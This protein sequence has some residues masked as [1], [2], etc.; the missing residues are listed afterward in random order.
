MQVEI[1]T[2]A[3]AD[4]A[5][6]AGRVAP[7]KGSAYDRAAGLMLEVD[8]DQIDRPVTIRSTDMDNTFLARLGALRVQGSGAWRLPAGVLAG[9]AGQLPLGAGSTVILSDRGGKIN[10]K[11]GKTKANLHTMDPSS[12]PPFAWFDESAL[13]PVQNLAQLLERVSWAT[14]AGDRS[15][16][17]SGVHIDGERLVACDRVKMAEVPCKVPIDHPI[18]VP[19][20]SL[21]MIMRNTAEVRILAVDQALHLMTDQDTQATSRI[22]GAPYPDLSPMRKRVDSN[23]SFMEVS[24]EGLLEVLRRQMVLCKGDR[25]PSIKVTFGDG[26]VQVA[27]DVPELGMIEDEIGAVG[28]AL[29]THDE[30]W[31]TPTVLQ[32][33]LAVAGAPTVTISYLA[34]SP[35]TPVNISDGTGYR[36]IAS[37]RTGP[38]P[39]IS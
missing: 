39:V 7:T 3:F 23:D 11:S 18:T 17:L 16:V 14:D 10:L 1:E 29:G 37:T 27:M 31:F 22:F 38:A 21:V 34:G 35:L 33:A 5:Q 36:C 24:V 28:G 6:K 19:L 25:Y 20:S 13:V 32:S 2:G 30:M 9:L 26:V 12:F 8:S 15:D 4:A